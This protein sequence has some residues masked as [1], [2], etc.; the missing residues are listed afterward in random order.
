MARL[1]GVEGSLLPLEGLQLAPV[2]CSASP[3]LPGLRERPPGQA[4]AKWLLLGPELPTGC[5]GVVQGGS[6]PSVL[7]KAW[8]KFSLQESWSSSWM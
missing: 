5:C 2:G 1:A 8:G 3:G 7:R 4:L 6:F